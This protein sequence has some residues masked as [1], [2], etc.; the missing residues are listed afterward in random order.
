MPGPDV[1]DYEP[2]EPDPGG[3]AEDVEFDVTSGQDLVDGLQDPSEAPSEVRRS[4]WA[5]VLLLDFGLFAAVVGPLLAHLWG[6]TTRGGAL[7]LAGTVALVGA[8]IRIRRFQ[9]S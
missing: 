1:P 2:E 7:F 9:R 8:A 6:W 5:I 4:F 3:A